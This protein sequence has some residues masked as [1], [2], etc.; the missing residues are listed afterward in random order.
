MRSTCRLLLARMP[1]APQGKLPRSTRHATACPISTWSATD[2]PISPATT[3]R[4]PRSACEQ[5]AWLGEHFAARGLRFARV[6]SGSL[7]RQT[8]TLRR[9]PRA[10][11]GQPCA[12]HRSALQR[13]RRRQRARRVSPRRRARAARDGRSSRAISPRSA[14]RCW[15]GRGRIEPFAGRR[16]VAAVRRSASRAELPRPA[17]TSTA[18]RGCWS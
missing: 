8:G 17:R 2:S 13:V 5:S 15:H 4:S 16:V 9:D 10:P 11:A 12:D 6:I 1:R 18:K 3:T 7:D 14:T